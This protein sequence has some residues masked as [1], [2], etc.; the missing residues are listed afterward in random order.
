M[1]RICLI[2]DE[3]VLRLLLVDT[4]EDE[5]YDVIVAKDGLEALEVLKSARP[6]CV[7]VDYMMPGLTGVEVTKAFRAFPHGEKIPV[8]MLTAKNSEEDRL[9]ALEAGIDHFILKPFSPQ[10]VTALVK[11]VLYAQKN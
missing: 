6:D 3:E 1:K 2:E 5:G 9:Q 4:L 8:I 11:K 7:M 10:A